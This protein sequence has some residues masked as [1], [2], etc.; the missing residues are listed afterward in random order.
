MT[1]LVVPDWPSFGCWSGGT[2]E[3]R[4]RRRA[5]R[6][7]PAR[8]ERRAGAQRRGRHRQERAAGA[9]GPAPP[10]LRLLR[11]T[12]GR[13][14]AGP[15]V[16]GLAALLR[17]T[18]RPRSTGCRRRRRRPS[19]SRWHCG[20]GAVADRFA[21]SAAV[22]TPADPGRARSGPVGLIVDD[23][24][25]LDRPSAEA[26]AFACRRLLADAGVRAGRRPAR[27][28]R[29]A[30]EA[31]LPDLDAGRARPRRHRPAGPG[32]PAP[33]PGSSVARIIGPTG[34]NPLAV[35]APGRRAG[36]AARAHP[37][38]RRCRCRLGSRPAFARRDRRA[39]ARTPAGRAAGGRRR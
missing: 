30:V 16:R 37:G 20:P 1:P 17:P 36:P 4:D 26:L 39:R 7:R 29:G 14:R 15:A 38:Q 33:T 18:R 24:H 19:A 2:P 25:L 34:G 12:R 11:A 23:A 32:A 8:P 21:V 9:R 22:L 35:I 10:G 5:A 13:G 28:A 27:R 3:P 31:G 6:R